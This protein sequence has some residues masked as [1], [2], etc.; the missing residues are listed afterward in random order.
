[1]PT[2]ATEQT[3]DD[4]PYTKM[5]FTDWVSFEALLIV[6]VGTFFMMQWFSYVERERANAFVLM[7]STSKANEYVVPAYQECLRSR[8]PEHT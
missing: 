1:M 8:N 4:Q 5:P 6:S 3:P 2:V 7:A